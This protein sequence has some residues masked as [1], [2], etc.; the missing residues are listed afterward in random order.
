MVEQ[1]KNSNEKLSV[2]NKSII[3]SEMKFLISDS[4]LQV[5]DN[6]GKPIVDTSKGA[7]SPKEIPN[8]KD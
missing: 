8:N 3:K 5:R 4:I 2:V 6:Q 7:D 1:N